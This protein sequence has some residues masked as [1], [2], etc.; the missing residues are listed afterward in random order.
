MAPRVSRPASV[1]LVVLGFALP[2]LAQAD[3]QR[4]PWAVVPPPGVQLKVT[5]TNKTVLT[6]TVVEAGAGQVTLRSI[7]V[8]KGAIGQSLATPAGAP[9]QGLIFQRPQVTVIEHLMNTYR[10]VDGVPDVGMARYVA[11]VLG[12]D[13]NVELKAGTRRLRGQIQTIDDMGLTVAHGFRNRDITRVDHSEILSLKASSWL[14]RHP[15]LA[16]T[17][18]GAGAGYAAATADCAARTT[19]FICPLVGLSGAGLGAGAGAGIGAIVGRN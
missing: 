18:I 16:G 14:G 9:G 3:G 13:R 6:G 7:Y 5:L 11:R 8:E 10:A 19:E 15:I 1:A 12:S 17:L 2:V 4:D